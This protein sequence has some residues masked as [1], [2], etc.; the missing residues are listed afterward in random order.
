MLQDECDLQD[1][2]EEQYDTIDMNIVKQMIGLKIND[3]TNHRNDDKS[4]EDTKPDNVLLNTNK[5]YDFNEPSSKVSTIFPNCIF[6]LWISIKMFFHTF[7]CNQTIEIVM[8]ILRESNDKV[9][10]VSQW[11]S[12]LSIVAEFLHRKRVHY[13]EL[14]GK[15]PIKDRNNIVVSFNNP[16]SPE[17]VSVKFICC[18][19][20]VYS[21][22][23]QSQCFPH[24]FF[25]I[26]NSFNSGDDVI[27]SS[28]WRW[29]EFDRC[30]SFDFVGSSLESTT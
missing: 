6:F 16:D 2:D 28:W 5:V 25:V 7:Q 4:K 18:H 21:S 13:V 19:S 14:T 23:C 10:V 17:R 8:R 24:I 26:S 11:T 15:T 9:V 29:F 27:V 20:Y 1:G 30:K 3:E 22:H 12:F